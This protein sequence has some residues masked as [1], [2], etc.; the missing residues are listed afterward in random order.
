MTLLLI[1]ASSYDCLNLDKILQVA[2]ISGDTAQNKFP[3]ISS[4][5]ENLN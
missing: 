5:S 1:L 2:H 3:F 4:R